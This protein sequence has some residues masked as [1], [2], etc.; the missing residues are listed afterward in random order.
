MS[1]EIP[2]LDPANASEHVS[3]VLDELRREIPDPKSLAAITNS[4]T[5]HKLNPENSRAGIYVTDPE[6]RDWTVIL[7]PFGNDVTDQM[8]LRALVAARSRLDADSSRSNALVLPNSVFGQPAFNST[9]SDR[10]K[11]SKGEFAPFIDT[12][13]PVIEACVGGSSNVL[14]Y[15]WSQGAAL[16]PELLGRMATICDVQTV[17]LGDAPNAHC[18]RGPFGLTKDFLLPGNKQTV[19]AMQ[20]SN[21][22]ALDLVVDSVDSIS[23]AARFIAGA[24][25][26]ENVAIG[27]GMTGGNHAED[28]INYISNDTRVVFAGAAGSLILREAQLKRLVSYVSERRKGETRAFTIGGDYGHAAGDH[29]RLVGMLIEAATDHS[30]QLYHLGR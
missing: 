2:V 21:F 5:D 7:C 23:G 4:A 12:M 9:R 24:L 1:G 8:S 15:I 17:I 18:G 10:K 20:D 6:S 19:R 26:A 22:A 11:M 13:M 25:M 3:T 14:S 28:I 27:R 29:M 30:I 16:A